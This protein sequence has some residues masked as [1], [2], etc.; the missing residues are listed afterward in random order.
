MTNLRDKIAALSPARRAKI[1]R[2]AKKLIA[3]E[4]SLQDLDR[5]PTP[6]PFL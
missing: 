3:E 1:A 2:R 6:T 5:K 4:L